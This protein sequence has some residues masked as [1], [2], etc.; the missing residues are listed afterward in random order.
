MLNFTGTVLS[1]FPEEVDQIGES[2]FK[3][4]LTANGTNFNSWLELFG[5]ENIFGQDLTSP[6]QFNLSDPA[7]IDNDIVPF[8][9][10]G[11]APQTFN[12]NDI[13]IV[14]SLDADILQ[15]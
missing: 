15:C 7:S 10:T 13:V 3:K 8:N 12:S 4:F 14:S 1:Q 11:L 9:G 2:N 6:S 5:P